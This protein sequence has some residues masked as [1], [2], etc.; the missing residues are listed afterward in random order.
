VSILAT[1]ALNNS[2]PSS[3][4]VLSMRRVPLLSIVIVGLVGAFGCR[5]KKQ[6]AAKAVAEN[7]GREKARACS[8]PATGV[9]D[10]DVTITRECV[11]VVER[12]VKVTNGAKLVI[13]PGVTLAF[14]RGTGLRIEKGALVARGA[15]DAKI[16]FTSHAAKKAAGDWTGISLADDGATTSS[17]LAHVAIE[18]AGG[19]AVGVTPVARPDAGPKMLAIAALGS[20]APVALPAEAALV[21]EDTARDVTLEH[22][23][24]G[25]HAS[26]AIL[27]RKAE[28][29]ARCEACSSVDTGAAS[30]F[31]PTETL[32]AFT[33]SSFD[34]PVHVFGTVTRKTTWPT[35]TVPI[36]IDE[37]V[38]IDSGVANAPAV[39]DV[40]DGNTL[41]LAPSVQLIV[42]GTAND[43]TG[44]LVARRVHFTWM[45]TT[46]WG[47]IELHDAPTGTVLD[48]C[49]L[50]HGGQ[51]WLA[52][53]G[54]G[55][56]MLPKFDR[57]ITIKKN[58]FVDND[59]PAMK[60]DKDCHGYDRPSLGNTS[61]GKDLCWKDPL[62]PMMIDPLGSSGMLGGLGD[63][64]DSMGAGFGFGGLGGSGGGIG[65]GGG[66]VGLGDGLGTLGTPKAAPATKSTTQTKNK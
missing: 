8:L 4:T 30:M 46:P 6:D 16:V 27:A 32:A 49:T 25:H 64:S 14:E 28:S 36:H 59:A 57:G 66:G 11:T 18:Y 17:V 33:A 39:L 13:E 37:T 63:E 65:G 50:D 34:A 2:R 43:N 10:K 29:L 5:G 38:A 47:S 42:G 35:L 22:V 21:L 56:V 40:G 52:A 48:G 12:T 3:S 19:K 53:F 1:V 9:V 31:V 58:R 7:E 51:S 54:Y 60:G 62:A 41:K 23:S 44:A 45:G 20:A 61:M 26:I 55:V 24:F 15:P